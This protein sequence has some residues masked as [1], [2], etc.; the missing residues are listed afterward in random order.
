MRPSFVYLFYFS[1][2]LVYNLVSSIE[3]YLT[4]TS[5][6]SFNIAWDQF[7]PYL[8]I[9]HESNPNKILFQTLRSWPFITVGF[10]T[11]SN[12]PIVDGNFKENEWTL[13]ETPYQNIKNVQFYEEEFLISGEVWG[14][15]TK[16]TYDLK[17]FIPLDNDNKY[18]LDS[19]LSFELNVHS[20]YGTFNRVFLNYY[21]DAKE[22]F[23]GF[24]TQVI[25]FSC[26][27]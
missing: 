17:F 12:P 20:I 10:A 23:Y 26:F 18:K 4:T 2:K 21:C 9:T 16:A 11:D 3:E 8:S 22:N 6:G 5:I 24:G 27:L 25:I 13:F 15:V 7:D 14:L 19:Q 1:F